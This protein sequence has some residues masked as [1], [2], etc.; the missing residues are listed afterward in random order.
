MVNPMFD[1]IYPECIASLKAQQSSRK[2]ARGTH[3]EEAIQK[4]NKHKKIFNILAMLK[5]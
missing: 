4:I 2:R 5:T 3:T 1:E